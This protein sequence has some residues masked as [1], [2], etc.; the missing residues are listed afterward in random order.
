MSWTS[1][2]LMWGCLLGVQPLAVLPVVH[3]EEPAPRKASQEPRGEEA[4]KNALLRLASPL[5]SERAAAAEELGRRGQRFRRQIGEALRPLLRKDPDPAVRTAAGRALGR[6]GVRESVP[7]LTAALSDVSAEVRAAAA[8]SL[9][10]L[11]DPS[12]LSML[13]ARTRDDDAKVRTWSVR[14]LAAARDARATAPLIERL[15]DGER[16]VRLAAIRGL[17]QLDA[18]E[19]LA[20]LQAY[21]SSQSAR[22]EE[23]K[24]EVVNAVV[25]IDASDRVVTL[26]ALYAAAAADVQQKRRVLKALAQVGDARALPMLRKLS[27]ERVDSRGLRAPAAH[28]YA[29]VLARTAASADAG[30]P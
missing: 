27:T 12:A 11:P 10:R 18:G 23:E 16:D 7:E 13:V 28:A 20:P 8:A 1:R 3:A 22:D 26:L 4:F 17:G 25:A 24:E 21:L 15:S 29:A 6:L 9:W 2:V 14:A 19:A 30:A 5:A